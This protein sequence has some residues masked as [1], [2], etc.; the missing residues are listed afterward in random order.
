MIVLLGEGYTREQFLEVRKMRIGASDIGAIAGLN[1]FRTPLD[2]WAEKT[3]RVAG[4]EENKR[5][6]FGR[7]VEPVV[8]ELFND[9]LGVSTYKVDEVWQHDNHDWAIATPDYAIDGTDELV[10]IK[11][12][13]IN[14]AK[15]WS[16][17]KAPDSYALQLQW[18]LEIGGIS[19]GY[20]CGLLAGD[21]E[22]LCTPRIERSTDIG[23]QLLELGGKFM[24]LI[25]TDTPPGAKA[26]DDKLIERLFART[27]VE[28]TLPDNAKALFDRHDELND[29]IK[30]SNNE[31]SQIKS[32][33]MMM[34]GT[35]KGGMCG[36]RRAF[37]TPYKR[38]AF[39]S[40]EVDKLIFKVK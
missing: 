7:L 30:R 11:T 18:Q 22:N 23:Q 2:V 20:L 17:D 16:E 8:A 39:M 24:D 15:H 29:L 31:L 26:G 3:G 32:E 14:G 36:E 5:M 37:F 25:R 12:T 13:T 40:P 38:K 27:E 9:K 33:L 1:P 28:I 10:E 34:L 35:A 6:K 19:G 4:V 21:A